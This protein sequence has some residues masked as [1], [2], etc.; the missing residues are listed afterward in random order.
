MLTRSGIKHDGLRKLALEGDSSKLPPE[1]VNH[2]KLA[3]AALHVACH[4]RE[5]AISDD[6]YIEPSEKETG[7]HLVR[8]FQNTWLT[9]KWNDG[10]PYEVDLEEL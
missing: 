1:S 2:I 8:V 9:F 7:T 5:V 3:I 4:P 6:E 10:G